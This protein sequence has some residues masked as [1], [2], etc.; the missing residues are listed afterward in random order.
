MEV[1]RKKPFCLVLGKL[2]S[3][4]GIIYKIFPKYKYGLNMVGK[5]CSF[6]VSGICMETTRESVLQGQEVFHRGSRSQ[7][8]GCGLC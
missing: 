6:L 4:Y 3:D 5:F 2:S 1:T 8:V 7:A